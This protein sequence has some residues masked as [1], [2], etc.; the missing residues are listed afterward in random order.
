MQKG[1][2]GGGMGSI[3]QRVNCTQSNTQG[4]TL[5]SPQKIT[6]SQ[7][8]TTKQ[9]TSPSSTFQA[10][11]DFKDNTPRM[12]S[13]TTTSNINAVT[14]N[15][16]QTDTSKTGENITK[17][18]LS[19][20]SPQLNIPKPP[21]SAIPPPPGM[22]NIQ[23]PLHG[24]AGQT[25]TIPK[26]P[27]LP[28]PGMFAGPISSSTDIVSN[29]YL[30]G[31]KKEIDAADSKDQINITALILSSFL[32]SLKQTLDIDMLKLSS[33]QLKRLKDELNF[34]N[35]Y[36][37]SDIWEKYANAYFFIYKTNNNF[38]RIENYANFKQLVTLS[39]N[40]YRDLKSKVIISVKSRKEKVPG[41]SIQANNIFFTDQELNIND[42]KTYLSI[43]RWF[44][45]KLKFAL[46]PPK[47]TLP[48][49]I[50]PA[51]NHYKNE[52]HLKEVVEKIIAVSSDPEFLRKIEKEEKERQEKAKQQASRLQNNTQEMVN[53]LT[54]AIDQ[55]FINHITDPSLKIRMQTAIYNKIDKLSQDNPPIALSI[56]SKELDRQNPMPLARMIV[57]V[58][59][60]KD[61]LELEKNLD[62]GTNEEI[63]EYLMDEI[64]NIWHRKLTIHEI[65]TDP[66]GMFS[67]PQEGHQPIAIK[68]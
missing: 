22:Q 32:N 65:T 56:M 17:E 9:I 4:T 26:A 47:A 35:N 66:N 48:S 15:T 20:Q 57:T 23:P 51:S 61:L 63:Y 34:N 1:V 45:K 11:S 28:P 14:I 38:P 68:A 31:L 8:T 18:N 40:A 27:P 36:H 30:S 53:A 62:Y 60:E 19:S 10:R 55:Y 46:T 3:A 64:N 52:E 12:A 33:S 13:N 6:S 7:N 39:I 59:T 25:G 29:A 54:S 50:I 41:L 16:G 24:A 67:L 58:S 42:Q 43:A 5:G 37:N 2:G 21:G 44:I 49:N